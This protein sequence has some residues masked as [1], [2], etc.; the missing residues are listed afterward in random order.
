MGAIQRMLMAGA[1]S[2]T[3]TTLNPSDKGANTS[4]SGGNL[5]AT[6]TATG[7]GFARS[8]AA[9]TG[10]RYF[11]ARYDNVLVGTA[12]IA[13]GVAQSTASNTGS[14]GYSTADGW[15]FWGQSTGARHNGVTA[16]AGFAGS[17]DV[18]GFAVDVPNQRMW[19]R[20][21]GSWIQGDPATNTLPIWTNLTGTLYAAACPWQSGSIITMRFDPA[22][23]SNAAPSGFSPVT[24]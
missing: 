12:T 6:G 7:S 16:L 23:F 22:S 19:I 11:E 24:A 9:L 14:L 18:F 2:V 17:S 10:K 13:V 4:L 21:N 15:A 3:Y 8:V 20:K 1:A 5:I